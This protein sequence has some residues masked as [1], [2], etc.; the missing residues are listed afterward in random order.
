LSVQSQGN[1]VSQGKKRNPW[2]DLFGVGLR[3]RLPA[4]SLVPDRIAKVLRV[5]ENSRGGPRMRIGAISSQS[6]TDKK[7]QQPQK[8]NNAEHPAAGPHARPELT[9][10]AKTPGTG[11]L[12][13]PENN[14]GNQAPTG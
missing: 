6:N 11:M 3:E 14:D 9:D 4:P 5:L 10:K 1:L 12:P 8:S 13:D 2:L 7:V